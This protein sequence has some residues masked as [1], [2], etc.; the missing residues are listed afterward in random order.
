MGALFFQLEAI[1]GCPLGRENCLYFYAS[2]IINIQGRIIHFLRRDV[3]LTLTFCIY[4]SMT[5]EKYMYAGN[6]KGELMFHQIPQPH[7]DV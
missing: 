7:A 4:S 3:I 5:S 1:G 6:S 2:P